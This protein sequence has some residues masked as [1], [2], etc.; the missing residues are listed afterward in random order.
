VPHPGIAG[1]NFV[2]Y[3]LAELDRTLVIPGLG[4]VEDLLARCPDTGLR[5]LEEP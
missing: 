3:P 4:V 5:R 1:R 2:L